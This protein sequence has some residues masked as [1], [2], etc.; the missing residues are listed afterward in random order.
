MVSEAFKAPIWLCK[1][2]FSDE[3]KLKAGNT[4]FLAKPVGARKAKAIAQWKFNESKEDVIWSAAPDEKCPRAQPLRV[5]GFTRSGSSSKDWGHCLYLWSDLKCYE[6]SR[7]KQVE[8]VVWEASTYS[9]GFS[10]QPHGDTQVH[11]LFSGRCVLPSSLL[12]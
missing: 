1:M 9:E 10:L 8:L 2:K 6:Q 12:Q 4:K 3:L 11:L 7:G 5:R